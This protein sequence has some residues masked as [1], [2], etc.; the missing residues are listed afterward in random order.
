MDKHILNTEV[1]RALVK[2]HQSPKTCYLTILKP[3]YEANKLPSSLLVRWQRHAIIR[4]D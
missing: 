1:I 2:I 4:T 3:L